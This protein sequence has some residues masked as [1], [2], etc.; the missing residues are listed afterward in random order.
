MVK[1]KILIISYH[2]PPLA[3]PRGT[4]WFFFANYLADKGMDLDIVSVNPNGLIGIDNK[5]AQKINKKINVKYIGNQLLKLPFWDK[6]KDSNFFFSFISRVI[7]GIVKR[8]SYPDAQIF[9]ALNVYRH[10]SKLK[11]AN[12]N[13]MITVSNP[14]SSLILGYFIRKKLEL[15][16]ICDMGDPWSFNNF[17]DSRRIRGKLDKTIE[18]K[19]V[20]KAD[21][22][23]VTTDQTRSLFSKLYPS[24]KDKFFTIT[25]GYD[26]RLF[27]NSQKCKYI[28]K[29]KLSIVYTGRLYTKNRQIAELL[30]AL[31]ATTKYCK[32]IKFVFA[33]MVSTDLVY[34]TNKLGLEKNIDILGYLPLHQA[35]MLQKNADILLYLGNRSLTQLPGKIFE[36]IGSG[37]PIFGIY[38]LNGDIGKKMIEKKSLG[39]TCANDRDSIQG[40]LEKIVDLWKKGELNKIR[41]PQVKADCDWQTTA[42]KFYRVMTN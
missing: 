34:Q 28:D 35:A 41:D 15:N 40:T 6:Y 9:W 4:R 37:S 1:N 7:K 25:Q 19:V 36:Y 31:K 10:I 23:V 22:I 2:F 5:L 24:L 39:L 29:S 30:Y 16:W 38:Y 21:K 11:A 13:C 8:I 12:Y 3:T 33:G 17:I 27:Q 26:P 32:D 42:E 20:K 18:K 14:I